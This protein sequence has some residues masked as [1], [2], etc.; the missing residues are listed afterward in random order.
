MVRVLLIVGFVENHNLPLVTGDDEACTTS[1]DG[2]NAEGL[3]WRFL[4]QV[5]DFSRTF[6]DHD[7][8]LVS[9]NKELPLFKPAM[10]SVIHRDLGKR[11]FFLQLLEVCL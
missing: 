1:S 7:L 9:R 11:V 10:A 3:T 4:E 6:A 8:T 2:F 5:L